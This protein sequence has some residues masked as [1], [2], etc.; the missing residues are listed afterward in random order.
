MHIGSNQQSGGR[1]GDMAAMRLSHRSKNLDWNFAVLRQELRQDCFAVRLIFQKQRYSLAMSRFHIS[2]TGRTICST[3]NKTSRNH[4]EMRCYGK[5]PP[6]SILDRFN[7]QLPCYVTYTTPKTAELI[8]ENLHKS[9][10][11]SGVI[12]GVGPRYCPSIEDKIVRFSS[13]K[14]ASD[15]FGA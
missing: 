9:P 7:G 11:Y 1:A 8:H 15:F 2:H 4:Q 13:Q 6:G 14:T 3:W 12:K 10:L 5:Y